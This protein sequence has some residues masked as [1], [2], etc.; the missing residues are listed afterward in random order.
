MGN[1]HANSPAASES[2]WLELSKHNLST[3]QVTCDLSSVRV[4]NGGSWSTMARQWTHLPVCFRLCICK[5]DSLKYLLLQ[6]GY[7]HMKGRFSLVS[8][9]DR[10]RVG[11]TPDTRRTSCRQNIRGMETLCHMW[12]LMLSH[13]KRNAEMYQKKRR[14]VMIWDKK[15]KV[16]FHTRDTCDRHH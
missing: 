16:C 15:K 14:Q 8:D 11:A 13:G 3:P 1:Q 10:T 5:W 12:T 9:A 7:A 2:P 6:P 4:Q